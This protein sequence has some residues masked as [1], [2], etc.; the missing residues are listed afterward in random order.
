MVEPGGVELRH[1]DHILHLGH[2]LE[3]AH[4]RHQVV[5]PDGLRVALPA[6]DSGGRVEAEYLDLAGE[7]SVRKGSDALHAGDDHIIVVLLTR[8]FP[9]G[10]PV[11]GVSEPV[12]SDAQAGRSGA[13][14]LAARGCKAHRV[15]LVEK[16]LGV[17]GL[18][19]QVSGAFVRGEVVEEAVPRRL[20]DA[21]FL[22]AASP[23]GDVVAAAQAGIR[24]DVVNVH[25]GGVTAHRHGHI[26]DVLA[27]AAQEH[28][29]EP[30]IRGEL[31]V[32]PGEASD[33]VVPYSAD[34]VHRVH[35]VAEVPET[36]P[37]EL[38]D[39]LLICAD[40]LVEPVLYGSPLIIAPVRKGPGAECAAVVQVLRGREHLAVLLEKFCRG[41]YPL[42]ARES[43]LRHENEGVGLGDAVRSAHPLLHVLIASLQVVGHAVVVTE[44][45]RL[46]LRTPEPYVDDGLVAAGPAD[47]NGGRVELPEVLERNAESTADIPCEGISCG[48]FSGERA[49]PRTVI[50]GLLAYGPGVVAQLAQTEGVPLSPFA[51]EELAL[52]V[53][54]SG[55]GNSYSLF[56][57]FLIVLLLARRSLR[58]CCR[59]CP[60]RCGLRAC[61]L[62]LYGV[63]EYPPAVK[64]L[65]GFSPYLAL[66]GS[67]GY[68][69]VICLFA[70]RN[71]ETES[72][73]ADEV[74]VLVSVED[75][76]VYEPYLVGVLE[77]VHPDDERQPFA[78]VLLAVV[79]AF[80]LDDAP[81]RA[82]LLEGGPAYSAHV[83]AS[84]F[85]RDEVCRSADFGIPDPEG[86]KDVVAALRDDGLDLAGV[87]DVAVS[88]FGN[89]FLC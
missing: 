55:L 3:S 16:L 83:A 65:H 23:V 27:A 5:G 30:H 54:V 72:E 64:R 19:H 84:S 45:H 36:V 48:P 46:G 34:I 10:H 20:A 12:G 13:R 15:N 9:A 43:G 66:V 77:E 82:V 74:L 86:V 1:V 32:V 38:L 29:P 8:P 87:D 59:S 14:G 28:I 33:V 78:A 6:E 69:A 89:E 21:R 2:Y 68:V 39:V 47:L 17:L 51:D 42:A 73:R 56:L 44:V 4:N 41:K 85:R 50:L 25:L 35:K 62:F 52:L 79:H 22:G 57:V 31:G 76:A 60:L 67:E 40:D 37:L 49:Y 58:G 61:R 11:A 81:Y 71:S 70:H 53:E 7:K 18:V 80:D 75:E 26:P 63:G 88:F 24:P